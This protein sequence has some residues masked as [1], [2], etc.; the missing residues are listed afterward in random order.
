M[1]KLVAANAN[2]ATVADTDR[3][4]LVDEDRHA[5]SWSSR[6][7]THSTTAITNSM[8]MRPVFWRHYGVGESVRRA[9]WMQVSWAHKL[10][11]F[12]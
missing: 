6:R 4:V 9:V 8:V 3:D 1:K 12:Q 7:P 5:V 2:E 11:G 10:S